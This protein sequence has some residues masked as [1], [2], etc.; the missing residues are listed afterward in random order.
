MKNKLFLSI[1][2]AIVII[3]I[4]VTVIFVFGG[5]NSGN[6]TKGEKSVTIIVEIDKKETKVEAF[7]DAS[8]LDAL[9]LELIELE[10][11]DVKFSF[12]GMGMNIEGFNGVQ[13]N[14]DKG[15]YLY[16][17]GKEAMHTLSR[18]P[19]ESGDE[20]RFRYENS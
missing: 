14:D 13:S 20:Y 1:I 11:I 9:M 2:I 8:Y 18:V 17:N 19:V 12:N 16:V 4:V 7:T 3:A 5:K 10:L 15:F 6:G